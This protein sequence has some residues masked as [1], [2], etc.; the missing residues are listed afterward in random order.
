MT[1]LKPLRVKRYRA[2]IGSYHVEL[3]NLIRVLEALEQCGLKLSF[4]AKRVQKVHDRAEHFLAQIE[5]GEFDLKALARFTALMNE[6]FFQ[7]FSDEQ[8]FENTS[9]TAVQQ[10]RKTAKAL[11]RLSS[12]LWE[13]DKGDFEDPTEAD[14][15][16]AGEETEEVERL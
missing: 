15:K 13:R 9:G 10:M 2:L 1:E 5:S 7:S 6:G 11:D 8:A 3:E 16:A 12:F 14:E 4:S